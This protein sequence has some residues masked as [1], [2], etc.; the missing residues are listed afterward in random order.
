MPKTTTAGL[1]ELKWAILELAEAV[2]R[3]TGQKWSPE[4]KAV[5]ELL[6]G[7]YL[8]TG[9]GV[10]QR[11]GEYREAGR[12]MAEASRLLAEQDMRRAAAQDEARCS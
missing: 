5:L 6:E 1:D 8:L 9:F 10:S 4:F 7:E 3:Q 11:V 2:E 12:E